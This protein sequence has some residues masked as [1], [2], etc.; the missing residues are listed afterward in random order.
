MPLNHMDIG[1]ANVIKK[2][3]GKSAER[4]RLYDLGLC[5]GS[6]VTIVSKMNGNIIVSIKD[7]RIALASDIAKRIMV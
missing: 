3:T 5:E 1:S 4:Q 6:E 2:I 7:S